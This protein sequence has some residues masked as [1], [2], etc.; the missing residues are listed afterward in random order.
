MDWWENGA[1]SYRSAEANGEY[2]GIVI[3]GTDAY[4]TG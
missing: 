3:E 4:F 2:C 1:E